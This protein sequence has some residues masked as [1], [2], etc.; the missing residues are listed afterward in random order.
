MDTGDG[1]PPDYANETQPNSAVMNDK[2]EDRHGEITEK[3]HF[4]INL[5]GDDFDALLFY[6]DSVTIETDEFVATLNPPENINTDRQ[7]LIAKHLI[8]EL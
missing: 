4:S 3:Q 6:K 1:R 5:T 7:K 2:S 8:D